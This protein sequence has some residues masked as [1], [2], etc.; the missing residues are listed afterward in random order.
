M[1]QLIKLLK[2]KIDKTIELKHTF[3]LSVVYEVDTT[4]AVS[5][6]FCRICK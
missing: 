2:T 5:K 3:D 4:G 1:G 6:A